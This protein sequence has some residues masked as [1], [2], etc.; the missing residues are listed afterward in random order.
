[1]FLIT[2]RTIASEKEKGWYGAVKVG[3]NASSLCNAK[4]YVTFLKNFMGSFEV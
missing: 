4:S 2:L 1:M 3:I